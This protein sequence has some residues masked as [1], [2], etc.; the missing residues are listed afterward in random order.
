[1]GT[2]IGGSS[3]VGNDVRFLDD[4]GGLKAWQLQGF[5]EGW[6]R[7]LSS[8]ELLRV[9]Q[10]SAHVVLA[11]DAASGRV[12]GFITAVTDGVFAAYIPLLEVLRPFRKRGIGTRLVSLMLE[13]LRDYR[14]VDLMCDEGLVGFY[15]R[16]GLRP[17]GGMGLRR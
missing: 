4:P 12:V 1:M 17:M 15:R 16:F 2:S 5:C 8:E 3:V 14:M 13:K 9:V 11:Q 10:G 7:P 6:V